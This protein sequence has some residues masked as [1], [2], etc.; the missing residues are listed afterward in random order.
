[1]KRIVL[2]TKAGD[3]L[4]TGPVLDKNYSAPDGGPDILEMM[5]S[6]GQFVHTVEFPDEARSLERLLD[7]HATHRVR[8]KKG[9]PELELRKKKLTPQAMLKITRAGRRPA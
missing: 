1:M 7:F 3:I 9:K 2:A 4:A 8:V 6:R 5:P